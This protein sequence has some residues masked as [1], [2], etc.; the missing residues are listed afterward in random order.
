MT[1][2]DATN[3]SWSKNIRGAVASLRAAASTRRGLLTI[4]GVAIVGGLGLNWSWLV[5]AGIAPVLLS[6]LPCATM[7]ALGL[8]AMQ[9]SRKGA[10]PGPTND[11]AQGRG[12]ELLS[13]PDIGG[14][15]RELKS[16]CNS[17]L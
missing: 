11:P 12:S 17:R 14:S 16:D 5:A 3:P 2:S 4:A 13:S 1:Y 15:S 8:C 7:C 10:V 9:M 6:L